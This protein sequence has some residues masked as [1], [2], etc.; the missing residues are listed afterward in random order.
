MI[1]QS[2]ADPSVALS[3]RTVL[4]WDRLRPVPGYPVA[5]PQDSFRSVSPDPSMMVTL[6]R[7]L[8]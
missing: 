4:N 2:G 3:V 5:L 8:V 1:P 7:K 6:P